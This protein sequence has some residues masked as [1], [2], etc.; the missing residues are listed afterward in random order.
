MKQLLAILAALTCLVIVVYLRDA[1]EPSVRPLSMS[2]P[3]PI[4]AVTGHLSDPTSASHKSV[5][6]FWKCESAQ[7]DQLFTGPVPESAEELEKVLWSLHSKTVA[8]FERPASA[9]AGRGGFGGG[10]GGGQFGNGQRQPPPLLVHLEQKHSTISKRPD[11]KQNPKELEIRPQW[12]EYEDTWRWYDYMCGITSHGFIYHVNGQSVVAPPSTL[13]PWPFLRTDTDIEEATQLADDESLW[14]IVEVELIG[15][16][17]RSRPSVHHG[18]AYVEPEIK[19]YETRE[20]NPVEAELLDHLRSGTE[21]TMAWNNREDFLQVVGAIRARET[22]L[23]CHDVKR[24]DL[25]GAF[26]YR[27]EEAEK[28]SQL[29]Q[30]RPPEPEPDLDKVNQGRRF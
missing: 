6:R 9:G 27:I 18:R 17:M 29:I 30:H 16:L 28:T 3:R 10:F 24:G 13:A 12:N 11:L 4:R 1:T 21:L 22:C 5:V 14:D 15:L 8:T 20:L 23:T 7:D 26:T 2:G 25:L 19:S